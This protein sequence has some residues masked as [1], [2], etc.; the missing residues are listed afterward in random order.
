MEHPSEDYTPHEHLIED[1]TRCMRGPDDTRPPGHT[2]YRFFF[3]ASPGSGTGIHYDPNGT[4]SWNSL[5][6]G[7][8]RLGIL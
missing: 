2:A 1:L 3:V 4:H 6:R 7:R 8:K 5:I